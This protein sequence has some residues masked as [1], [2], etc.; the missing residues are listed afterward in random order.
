MFNEF[1][2]TSLK[3]SQQKIRD[4]ANHHH[5]KMPKYL[6]DKELLNP[7]HRDTYKTVK[8][9]EEKKKK[10][11]TKRQKME[12]KYKKKHKKNYLAVNQE[13]LKG[14]DPF[15]ELAK[16]EATQE[17]SNVRTEF[18][19]TQKEKAIVTN[20]VSP[21]PASRLTL[22]QQLTSEDDAYV[23]LITNKGKLNI[24]LY[25]SLAPKTC[26]NFLTL[27]RSG[28]Y[29]NCPFHRLIPGFMVQC[30]GFYSTSSKKKS[31]TSCWGGYFEDE[32]NNQL[33]HDARGILSMANESVPNTNTYQFFITFI[34]CPHLDGKHSVFG[35]VVGGLDV[36]TDIENTPTSAGD[37]PKEPLFIEKV[38]IYRDP[39]HEDDEESETE[40]L[41]RSAFNNSDE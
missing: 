33:K 20:F 30:G 10:P 19:K 15:G 2:E 23:S 36:L 13:H 11:L 3:N 29:S 35:K 14:N 38:I 24:Q 18:N 31:K 5:I 34:P 37:A 27:C 6:D 32:F 12:Q 1:I 21:I 4:H 41:A 39:F 17:S 7:Y 22:Y 40:E 9:Q 16:M 28:T 8:E 25:C 26:D